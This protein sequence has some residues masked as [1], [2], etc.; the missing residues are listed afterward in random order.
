MFY[1]GLDWSGDP[2]IP[3]T[4]SA[5]SAHLVFAFVTIN[6]KH[7]ESLHHTFVELRNRQQLTNRFVFH[8]V[9]CPSSL[10]TAFFDT[11]RS[12]E[13]EIRIGVID[14]LHDWA[15]SG[16]LSMRGQERLRVAISDLAIQL[17]SQVV[18]GG[19]LLIDGSRSERKF[20]IGT[21]QTLRQSF[22][23][24]NRTGFRDIRLCADGNDPDG[25]IIQIADMVAGAVRRA[26]SLDNPHIRRIGNRIVP[27]E[28]GG[29]RK[30]HR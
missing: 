23:Q 18:S 21:R 16:V 9:D 1:T 14:K 28:T 27:W 19:Q 5:S 4:R 8:Y 13:L 29:K 12:A 26:G 25:E 10:A 3:S 6:A 15:D 30:P 20:G 11:I 24:A 7:R 22:D 2:G 17:P